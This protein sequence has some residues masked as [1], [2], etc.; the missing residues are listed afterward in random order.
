MRGLSCSLLMSERTLVRLKGTSLR[1]R[2]DF[3]AAPTEGQA[4]M[5]GRGDGRIVQGLGG[6]GHGSNDRWGPGEHVRHDILLAL[7]VPDV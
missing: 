2:E 7:D 1:R 5:L 4:G 6:G 3:T